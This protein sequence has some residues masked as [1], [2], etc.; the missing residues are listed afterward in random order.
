MQKKEYEKDIKYNSV[1][2]KSQ[3]ASGLI[4]FFT[5]E[6]P[7]YF[8]IPQSGSFYFLTESCNLTEQLSAFE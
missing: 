8:T 1:L 3:A 7:H 5:T 2:F 6:D 4:F